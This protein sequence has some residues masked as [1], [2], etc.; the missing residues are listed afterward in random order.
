MLGVL[1]RFANVGYFSSLRSQAVVL[2]MS[3]SFGGAMAM[4]PGA[5]HGGQTTTVS[6]GCYGVMAHP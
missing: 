2:A 6:E 1:A 5:R 4:V 3:R